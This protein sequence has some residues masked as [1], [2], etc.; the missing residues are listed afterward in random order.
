M[1]TSKQQWLLSRLLI[2]A[3]ILPPAVTY[4]DLK[5]NEALRQKI[6]NVGFEYFYILEQDT[7]KIN[8]SP[9]GGKVFALHAP[10]PYFGHRSLAGNPALLKI[11]EKVIFSHG[12]KIPREFKEMA[13]K[14]FD[15]ASKI[16][17]RV[18]TFHI[19]FFN[20]EEIGEEL[21]FLADLE[22]NYPGIWAAIEHEDAEHV[23]DYLKQGSKFLQFDGGYRWMM[24]PET[25][26][27]KL[28]QFFPKKKFGLCLDTAALISLDAPLLATTKKVLE[29]INH[30][31]LAGSIVGQDLASEID[32]ADIVGVV[33][34]L[35]KN[36]YKNFITAEINGAIG[37]KEEL[38]AKTY[39][40][41]SVVNTPLFKSQV[42]A[43][44][45]RHIYNS[46]RYL[47]DHFAVGQLSIGNLPRAGRRESLA[48][49]IPQAPGEP[50]TTN[51][52]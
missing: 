4:D 25:L 29:R 43:N 17:A 52:R 9:L 50:S 42:V 5:Y 23:Y 48:N 34:L 26:I 3:G 18:V 1:V 21:A 44:A 49:S 10:W 20:H 51:S 35:Y 45:Q 16:G 41:G 24:Q 12:K 32:R 28:D 7:S 2:P 14:S 46:C 27:K 13:Q 8:S 40:A 37:A 31:H 38:L 30:V 22:K 36:G 6:G 11:A 39:A 33:E 47:L 15:F 19:Y